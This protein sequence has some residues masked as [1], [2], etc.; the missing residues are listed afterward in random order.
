MPIVQDSS[1][2]NRD[3]LRCYLTLIWI[4]DWRLAC[5]LWACWRNLSTF[6]KGSTTMW[7]SLQTGSCLYILCSRPFKAGCLQKQYKGTYKNNNLLQEKGFGVHGSILRYTVGTWRWADCIP[8]Y[9]HTLGKWEWASS[10]SSTPTPY[11]QIATQVQ[12]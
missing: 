5:I 3:D 10:T 8:L 1:V 11:K 2:S 9:T 7:A 6:S 12:V 4:M